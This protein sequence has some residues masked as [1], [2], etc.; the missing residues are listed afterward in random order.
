M[1]HLWPV[2]ASAR[3]FP[4]SEVPWRAA[5]ELDLRRLA[6]QSLSGGSATFG[7]LSWTLGNASSTSTFEIAQG[8]GL[9]IAPN[10]DT[11][12]DA[13]DYTA[14]YA[15]V[16]FADL[17]PQRVRSDRLLVQALVSSSGLA[18]GG[19]SYALQCGSGA[20]G[21]NPNR[22]A[23][24]ATVLHD[25]DLRARAGMY[26]AGSFYGY[27]PIVAGEPTQLA[28]EWDPVM[29]RCYMGSGARWLRPGALTAIAGGGNPE[30]LDPDDGEG[31]IVPATDLVRLLAWR[32]TGAAAFTVTFHALRV[33]WSPL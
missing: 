8:H 3:V 12:L 32:P 13:S 15:S 17:L 23:A 19:Q 30:P 27:D 21:V 18:G 2:Q 33:L 26:S 20:V 29:A 31:L 9:R 16:K 11:R 1:S 6:D 10:D 5:F 7:G 25:G 22:Y 28:V 4:P 14:P 24:A